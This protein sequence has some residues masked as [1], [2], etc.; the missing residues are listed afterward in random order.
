MNTNHQMFSFS[1]TSL[2]IELGSTRIKAVL[3]DEK[4][5][6]L[7]S[8]GFEWENQL[9]QGIWTY[10]LEWVWQGVQ[11]VYREVAEQVFVRYGVRLERV[12][13]LG[14]S[15]MMHGYLPFDASGELLVPFRTWRNNCTEQAAETLSERF[16]FNVPQRWSVAHLYQAMLNQEPH[17]SQ[18]DYLTTLSGYVHWQLTG[19]KVLGVGDA[20]GMFPL[21]ENGTDYHPTYLAQFDQL[22]AESG[23]AWRLETLLP[24]IRLAGQSAGFLTEA[25]AKRLDP[26]GVLQAGIPCCPPEGDAGTGMVATNSIKVATGNLSAGTS[27]FA[28][29]VLEK[30]LSRYYRELDIVATPAGLP[31][32][33]AHSNNCSTALNRWMSLFQAVLQAFKLNPSMEEL[34]QRLLSQA[35]NAEADAGG[36]LPYGFYSGE[37]NLHLAQGVPLFIHPTASHFTLPNFMLSQLYSAFAS[38]KI[39]VD[40][41]REQEQ[42][43]LT[44]LLAHGGL[45]KTEGVA[46]Q[47]LA[48]MLNV[49]I[50][51]LT[52]ASEGGAWGMALLASYLRYADKYR[53]ET[54]LECEIF[55]Q[56][57]LKCYQPDSLQ[58]VGF[59]QFFANY[60]KQLPVEKQAIALQQ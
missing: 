30:P 6:I 52:T 58:A 40:I 1:Q 17:L 31:V 59:A 29:L 32:A 13:A 5:E 28:M 39:G 34:Y 23:Y 12:G 56:V 18:L 8:G 7:A 24:K 25:G 35:L 37:H 22:R 57:Q 47:T 2:G 60:L 46:A 49:P 36:L 53:L 51:T 27:A 19:E 44:S 4:G 42:L 26:T 11:A 9:E 54:Y 14:V 15:A 50:A 41:L 38:M 21:A 55:S 45:F 48:N 16:Q 33:M 3:I 20:S 43:T 10:P